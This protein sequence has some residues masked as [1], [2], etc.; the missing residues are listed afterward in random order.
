M[1]IHYLTSFSRKLYETTGKNLV[2]SYGQCQIKLGEPNWLLQYSEDD[3]VGRPINPEYLSWYLNTFKHLI[4]PNLGGTAKGCICG[5]KPG[6]A[7]FKV[8]HEPGCHNTLWNR[9]AYR[10]FH[11][12]VALKTYIDGLNSSNTPDYLVW[13][14]CDCYFKQHLPNQVIADLCDKYDICYL[15]GTKREAIESGILI[16]NLK[17]D[18]ASIIIQWFW[19]YQKQFFLADNRWDDGYQLTKVVESTLFLCKDLVAGKPVS[20]PADDCPLTPYIGH[21]KGTHVRDHQ[22]F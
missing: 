4:P 22:L 2:K 14:D 5:V 8:V 16:F 20:R 17:E 9:N 6:K 19:R 13:L 11:K 15:K 12:V 3:G 7:T 18:G 1:L 10:W 21:D